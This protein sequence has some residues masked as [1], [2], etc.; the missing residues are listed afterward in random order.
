MNFLLFVEIFSHI[1]LQCFAHI[2]RKI[3]YFSSG[4]MFLSN[5]IS[6]FVNW[7]SSPP[8]ST[9]CLIKSTSAI[10]SLIGHQLTNGHIL[11]IGWLTT[12]SSSTRDQVQRASYFKIAKYPQEFVFLLQLCL[13]HN[14]PNRV[15]CCSEGSLSY[16]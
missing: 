7:M 2:L 10:T 6:F 11:E 12:F 1:T 9:C 16:C 14:T 8:H 15:S 13:S 4:A 5:P 3:S